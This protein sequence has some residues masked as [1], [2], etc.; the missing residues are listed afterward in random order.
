MRL[1]VLLF[2]LSVGAS[3]VQADEVITWKR[4]VRGW[5]IAVDQTLGNSC[6]MVSYYQGN[7][8]V[9]AQFNAENG[10][11]EFMI[12][13]TDW[14]SIEAGKFYDVSIQFGSQSP[15]TGEAK[16]L[17]MDEFPVLS[18][19]VSFEDGKAD[20]FIEEFMR[21]TSAVLRYQDQ[22]IAH[23][24][25]KGTYAAMLEVFECQRTMLDAASGGSDPFSG[26]SG[27]SMDPF[28]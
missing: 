20:R 6:F 2:M 19:S 27:P 11:F 8:A 4:D 12:G 21:T 23:I 26:P 5:D 1:F 10:N 15:W 25:L 16:G 7:A 13:D 9:R 14:R 17:W 22:V 18:L 28:Q 24:S 3:R